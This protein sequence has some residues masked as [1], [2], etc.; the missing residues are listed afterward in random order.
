MPVP[1]LVLAWFLLQDV[2]VCDPEDPE[3][4]ASLGGQQ[5]SGA[6]EE[7]AGRVCLTKAREEDRDDIQLMVRGERDSD[8]AGAEDGDKDG[9]AGGD[10]AG[11]RASATRGTGVKG[12]PHVDS[13][14]RS[15]S[16][17]GT[18]TLCESERGNWVERALA[19][20]AQAVARYEV[21]PSVLRSDG[22]MAR[23]RQTAVSHGYRAAGALLLSS[24]WSDVAAAARLRQLWMAITFSL[25]SFF[26]GKQWAELEMVSLPR[27]LARIHALAQSPWLFPPPPPP[28]PPTGDAGIS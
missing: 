17:T 27:S 4:A 18:A 15:V 11:A 2:T 16:R 12:L 28:P 21:K 9:G 8:E 19:W 23:L 5:A 22:A 7:K 1:A 13:V 25:C 26:V 3:P 14:A 24:L 6:A 10:D 20:R